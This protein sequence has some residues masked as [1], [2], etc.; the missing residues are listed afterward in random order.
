[1]SEVKFTRGPWISVEG[2]TSGREV[3][4]EKPSTKSRLR[5]ARI[6]G[7]DRDANAHL[8]ASAP[9]LYEA[10]DNILKRGLTIDLIDPARAALAKARG[11]TP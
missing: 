3:L 11:E 6:G 8:I 9:E 1:M 2:T 10:L 7:P 5:V 4:A